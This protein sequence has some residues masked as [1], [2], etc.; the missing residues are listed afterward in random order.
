[1]AAR[2]CNPVRAR[3]A[4]EE[5]FQAY[6]PP[7]Y[8][9]IR[10]RGHDPETAEDLT[11]SFCA[12]L[13]ESNDLARVDRSKGKFRAFLLAACTHFLANEWDRQ[14]AQK[15][16]GDRRILSIDRADAEQRYGME[17]SHDLTPETLFARRWAITLLDQTLDDLRAEY[18]R[19]RQ[20]ERFEVLKLALTGDRVSLTEMAGRLGMAKGAVYVAVHRLRERY[21]EA[22]RARIAATLDHPSQIDDEIRDLFAALAARNPGIRESHS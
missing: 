9:F 4:L 8:A 12:Q 15:R 10:H 3:A 13:L 7:L 6:W 16:G 19:A 20:R 2:D 17:P 18:T 5:L 21:R 1:M 11:Q 14:R 22:L